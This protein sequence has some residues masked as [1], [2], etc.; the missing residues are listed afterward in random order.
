MTGDPNLDLM[1]RRTQGC[2]E[3]NPT[4]EQ[5]LAAI[6]E[7]AKQAFQEHLEKL[8]LQEVIKGALVSLATQQAATLAATLIS[9]LKT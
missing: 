6:Q 2:F 5:K 3:A 1:L 8:D 7:G 4:V 9:K